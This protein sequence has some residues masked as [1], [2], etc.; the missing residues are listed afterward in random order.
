MCYDDYSSDDSP[1]SWVPGTLMGLFILGLIMMGCKHNE[2]R[3]NARA[4]LPPELIKIESKQIVATENK[5]NYVIVSDKE[6][7]YVEQNQYSPIKV[8][9]CYLK[10]GDNDYNDLSIKETKCN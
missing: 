2:E 3:Y 8:G 1:F 9:K 4:A 6:T 5:V 7:F 10:K